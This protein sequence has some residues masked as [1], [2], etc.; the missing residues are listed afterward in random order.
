LGEW[1]GMRLGSM[2]AEIEADKNQILAEVISYKT[3]F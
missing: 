1:L 2:A 3:G